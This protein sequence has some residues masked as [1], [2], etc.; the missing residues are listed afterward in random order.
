MGIPEVANGFVECL[1]ILKK[2]PDG[3][4]QKTG[5]STLNEWL[6]IRDQLQQI[7]S[8]YTNYALEHGGEESSPRLG[9]RKPNQIAHHEYL[10]WLDNYPRL[11]L[12]IESPT[13]GFIKSPE[14]QKQLQQ[15][16]E[17][18][19]R[20]QLLALSALMDK[21]L[22]ISETKTITEIQR[23]RNNEAF[24]RGLAV[25][26]SDQQYTSYI[27][28]TIAGKASKGQ[29]KGQ[30][31]IV[32]LLVSFHGGHP[33]LWDIADLIKEISENHITDRGWDEHCN[34][35][36]SKIPTFSGVNLLKRQ[37]SPPLLDARN[38]SL[39]IDGKEYNFKKIS[40]YLNRHYNQQPN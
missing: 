22:G 23:E 2:Q 25:I 13:E 1:Q 15:L 7:F 17:K 33:N 16:I 38:S 30:A 24:V 18:H 32:E 10:K 6:P 27:Q 12:A 34:S 26:R 37:H 39:F 9:M 11:L 3:K 19:G 5:E 28:S 20:L 8:D 31:L 21:L 35:L 14:H 36:T 40:E 29:S 4:K